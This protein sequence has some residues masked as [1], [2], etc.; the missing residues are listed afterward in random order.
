MHAA[1]EPRSGPAVRGARALQRLSLTLL[2]ARFRA[3]RAT[4]L[5]TQ[6][7]QGRGRTT[8]VE[9]TGVHINNVPQVRVLLEVTVPGLLPSATSP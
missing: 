6:G 8:G 9:A 4:C 1:C 3:K 7:L 5:R 2:L